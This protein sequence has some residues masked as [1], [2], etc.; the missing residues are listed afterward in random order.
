MED[1][2]AGDTEDDLIESDFEE[3]TTRKAE[4]KDGGYKS[5]HG[6]SCEGQR[7]HVDKTKLDQEEEVGTEEV[8]G[9]GVKESVEENTIWQQ[10]ERSPVRVIPGLVEKDVVVN[11][12]KFWE[13][14]ECNSNN[15]KRSEVEERRQDEETGHKK[16]SE[17]GNSLVRTILADMLEAIACHTPYLDLNCN[18]LLPDA[19]QRSSEDSREVDKTMCEVEQSSGSSSRFNEKVVHLQGMWQS[20]NV[21]AHLN[22]EVTKQRISSVEEC[23]GNQGQAYVTSCRHIRPIESDIAPFEHES[24]WQGRT[25]A[26]RGCQHNVTSGLIHT[27]DDEWETTSMDDWS[28]PASEVTTSNT[29]YNKTT[30]ISRDHHTRQ[31]LDN[32]NDSSSNNPNPGSP[33]NANNCHDEEHNTSTHPHT[34]TQTESLQ[35]NP[36][37]GDRINPDTTI[38]DG[39]TRICGNHD[40]DLF[41]NGE[42][43]DGDDG[44]LQKSCKSF[45]TCIII[46]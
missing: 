20:G 24:S 5:A 8:S 28:D 3:C 21:D 13:S 43:L 18:Q 29:Q 36:A 12:K 42:A 33:N 34:A 46:P 2:G 35:P 16:S 44:N 32:T 11:E 37:T 40:D 30:M 6:S 38:I 9:D 23:P 17:T 26:I 25:D 41:I 4:A 22:Q 1:E 10:V 19:T 39:V 31:S 45:I 14:I 27:D 7:L 15:E